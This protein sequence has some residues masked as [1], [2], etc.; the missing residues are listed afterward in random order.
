MTLLATN[1]RYSES[2]NFGSAV[3]RVV[4]EERVFFEKQRSV[5]WEHLFF[6]ST[7]PLRPLL[8]EG[9]TSP[10][11]ARVFDSSIFSLNVVQGAS[12]KG[13][14]GSGR[15]EDALTGAPNPEDKDFLL[16]NLGALCAYCV[17]LGIEDLNYE[18]TLL[19]REGLKVID[20]ELVSNNSVFLFH[21]GLIWFDRRAAG[22]SGASR[23]LWSFL[24]LGSLSRE[25]T[26][27]LLRG[28]IEAMQHLASR[29]D[30]LRELIQG[31]ALG[32]RSLPIRVLLNSTA[33]YSLWLRNHSNINVQ[34]SFNG[35]RP[36]GPVDLGAL[37]VTQKLVFL[38]EEQAQ[39]ER[40]EI[41]Y[42]FRFY[43]GKDIFYLDS[44]DTYRKVDGAA[45]NV[46]IARA[47]FSDYDTLLSASRLQDFLLPIGSFELVRELLGNESKFELEVGTQA[48][49]VG[50][51]DVLLLR[52][53]HGSFMGARKL[54]GERR[55]TE[56]AMT[57]FR[58]S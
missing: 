53:E 2:H 1:D 29:A 11:L 42:F 16:F 27:L 23:M 12:G 44:P 49:V 34:D 56:A 52:T 35:E 18:N 28:F 38:K 21:T 8:T 30:R 55:T 20:A 31:L 24:K 10:W 32:E 39:L 46:A 57:V 36:P 6:G 33:R 50:D 5:F 9:I 45:R 48:Y 4:H 14:L 7:S 26:V 37:Q 58:L 22:M 41:P 43:G 13:P 15:I 17:A 54:D 40:G 47:R 19:T 51:E 3:R 25:E